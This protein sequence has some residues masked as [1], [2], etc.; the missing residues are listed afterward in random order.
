MSFVLADPI[1]TMTVFVLTSS[2]VST[3]SLVQAVVVSCV[4]VYQ[5]VVSFTAS[6][7]SVNYIKSF[8]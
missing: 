8:C 7:F 5:L 6:P 3:S 2:L 1:W 4:S